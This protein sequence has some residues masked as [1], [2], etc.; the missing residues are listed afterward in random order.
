MIS[1]Y[2]SS[3]LW[4]FKPEVEAVLTQDSSGNLWMMPCAGLRFTVVGPTDHPS[5]QKCKLGE[6][7]SGKDDGLRFFLEPGWEDVWERVAQPAD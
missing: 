6:V 7:F 3:R 5:G 2:H 1:D 4:R